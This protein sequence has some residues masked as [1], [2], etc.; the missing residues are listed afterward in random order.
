MTSASLPSFPTGNTPTSS[1]AAEALLSRARRL[2]SNTYKQQIQLTPTCFAEGEDP[3]NLSSF[4]GTFS[5]AT[6]SNSHL[7]QLHRDSFNSYIREQNKRRSS[8]QQQQQ[9]LS[10]SSTNKSTDESRSSP[11]LHPDS[12]SPLKLMD[13]SPTL[14]E[15]T[16]K[17]TVVVISLADDDKQEQELPEQEQQRTS[18]EQQTTA[19]TD[20]LA[21]D[22][23]STSDGN[24]ND[25]NNNTPCH[26]TAVDLSVGPSSSMPQHSLTVVTRPR[27][28]TLESIQEKHVDS[29]VSTKTKAQTEPAT[30]NNI[31]TTTMTPTSGRATTA[32][33]MPMP[34]DKPPRSR[35]SENGSAAGVV[36]GILE[37]LRDSEPRL[38]SLSSSPGQKQ[39]QRQDSGVMI[40]VTSTITIS[41]AEAE[42]TPVVGLSN[43][44][45]A[46]PATGAGALTTTVSSKGDRVEFRGSVSSLPTDAKPIFSSSPASNTVTSSAS[47][48]NTKTNVF[49][50]LNQ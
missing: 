20:P 6:S 50:T 5:S 47:S 26:T 24:N 36:H 43:A 11:D 33:T 34:L 10:S 32:S 25:N 21:N 8:L 42:E 23:G 16:H 15:H 30:P 45:N 7:H 39:E 18:E 17:P 13:V 4:P 28:L 46:S 1:Q 12:P 31:P 38:E 22:D 3:S 35:M 19:G 9:R 14:S 2:S 37:A 48:P 44:S 29:C 41:A 40:H 49:L 27:A